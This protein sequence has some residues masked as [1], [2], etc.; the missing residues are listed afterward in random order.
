MPAICR[1]RAVGSLGS[2][3]CCATRRTTHLRFHLRDGSW[4]RRSERYVACGLSSG[5]GRHGAERP[6]ADV[7]SRWPSRV[8]GVRVMAR[9]RTAKSRVPGCRWSRRPR[10]SGNPLRPNRRSD[11]QGGR[12]Q[13]QAGRSLNQ[14]GPWHP[15]ATN[16]AVCST[17]P[18]PWH[19]RQLSVRSRPGPLGLAQ[20]TVLGR[21]QHHRRGGVRQQ[22]AGEAPVRSP[23]N[24]IPA[25]MEAAA[26]VMQA[27]RA[28]CPST[29]SGV[30]SRVR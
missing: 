8:R 22:Q 2:S 17:Q 14:P 12:A 4:P 7:V 10:R 11:R 23:V 3:G 5:P 16:P 29:P 30:R 1:A 27:E 25:S 28:A 26:D 6:R 13:L 9:T 19:K 18:W 20:G 24:V 21:A 15:V